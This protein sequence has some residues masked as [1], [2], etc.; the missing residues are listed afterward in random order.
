M[1]KYNLN[2]LKKSE[3]I[4]ILLNDYGYEKEDLKDSDGKP[5]TNGV[6]KSII[7]QEVA[8]EDES[9][10]GLVDLEGIIKNS[11]RVIKDDDLVAVMNGLS[12][13]LV[14]RS[15]LTSRVWTFR[16]FG[17]VENLPYS[18]IRD[19]NPNVF[20][21]GWLVVLSPEI[22][23]ELGLEDVYENVLTPTNINEVFSKSVGELEKFIDSLPKDMKATFLY[24]SKELYR[25]GKLIN[26]TTIDLIQKKFNISF[27]DN[28][29][30]SD[31]V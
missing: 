6:L 19:M 2:G 23:R 16:E 8:D 17:Q 30:L 29:P 15:S 24:Q 18:E 11:R 27:D 1:T 7:T 4:D 26:K 12:G 20:K 13:R 10:S 5:Y 9:N 3:L 31:I 28:S 22:Q 14:H 21:D 25:K